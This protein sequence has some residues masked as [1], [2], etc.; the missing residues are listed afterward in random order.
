MRYLK[1][2][3]TYQASNLII[4]PKTTRAYSYGWWRFL[5][6]INGKTVFN[7]YAY[8]SSTTKHQWKTRS[9]LNELGVKIDIFVKCPAGL[10]SGI[11][12]ENTIHHMLR[13]SSFAEVQQAAKLF[14]KEITSEMIEDA[15]I[16]VCNAYLAEASKRAEKYDH[17]K[18]AMK[19]ALQDAK[20]MAARQNGS[21]LS[22][23]GAQ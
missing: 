12:A 7:S 21:H 5:D 2:S 4:D 22:L 16:D 8:S 20:I 17:K 3:Q 9:L 18:E 23:C 6:K 11:A 14:K 1:R 13:E 10:Q 19:M 15:E